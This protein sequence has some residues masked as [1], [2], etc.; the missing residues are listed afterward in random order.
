MDNLHLI[1][2]A[3]AFGTGLWIGLKYRWKPHPLDVYIS[4]DCILVKE[5]RCRNLLVMEGV[6]LHTN[7][8]RI[9]VDRTLT[10]KGSVD[11][12]TRSTDV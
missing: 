6:T 5:V 10:I 7:G 4:T 11:H 3:I 9:L 2:L 8:H 12:G 1:Y